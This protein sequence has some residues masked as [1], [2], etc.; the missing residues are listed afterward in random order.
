[1]MSKKLLFLALIVLFLKNYSQNITIN[2][3][4]SIGVTSN[5]Y[6]PG[7]FYAVHNGTGYNDF[8]NN[9]IYFNALR[10]RNIEEALNWTGVNSINGVMAVLEAQ[11]ADFITG[12][13]LKFIKH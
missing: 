4:I 5:L 9:G 1:M 2:P 10:I 13:T 6:K 7:M 3:N 12:S 8:A 11:K